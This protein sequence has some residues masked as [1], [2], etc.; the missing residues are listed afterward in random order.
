MS[1]CRC[2]DKDIDNEYIQVSPYVPFESMICL[3]NLLFICATL[4]VQLV[5]CDDLRAV[6]VMARH[7]DR[8]PT[9]TFPGD[10]NYQFMDQ[11]GWGSL[12]S[13]GRVHMY[14]LGRDLRLR[15]PQ[16][17]TRRTT[18][19]ASSRRERCLETINIILSGLKGPVASLDQLPHEPIES[20]EVTED[21]MLNHGAVDCPVRRES[22]LSDEGIKKLPRE[23][24]ILWSNISK[25]THEVYN[26]SNA[27]F[28]FDDRVDPIWSALFA[29]LPISWAS[30]DTFDQGDKVMDEVNLY[31]S[32]MP[33]EGK[34]SGV[35]YEEVIKQFKLALESE[36]V[37][38]FGYATHDTTL[39]P[40]MGNL[41]IWP[42][43][44]PYY[45]EALIFVL[46]ANASMEL[47]FYDYQHQWIPQVPAKINGTQ[48]TLEQFEAS[49]GHLIPLNWKSECGRPDSS[50]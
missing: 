29:D 27:F 3:A 11:L 47:F 30:E 31:L 1:L 8:W 22:I 17:T 9:I 2:V 33:I 36:E 21:A 4:S 28:V 5:N 35:F 18:K 44:R 20:I 40:V 37:S 19:A 50:V 42:G 15:Y 39:G 6:A 45:G 32:N 25:V 23:F 24:P 48:F 34:L 38:F 41:G 49:V 7:G 26:E 16:L 14:T 46:W 12:T 10:T 13:A 43:H